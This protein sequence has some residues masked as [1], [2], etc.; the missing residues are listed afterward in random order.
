MT[1][2]PPGLSVDFEESTRASSL[3]DHH[4]DVERAEA[5]FNELSRQLSRR[6]EIA[7]SGS[8]SS[9]STAASGDV[10]K[11]VDKDDD[12]FDLREY[13]TTSNDAHQKAGIK[14]KVDFSL[15]LLGL[16]L[17]FLFIRQNVG[18][19]WEDLQVE[20]AGGMDNKVIVMGFVFRARYSLSLLQF[21]VGTLGGIEVLFLLDIYASDRS[22]QARSFHFSWGLFSG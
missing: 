6:S 21:Y 9:G 20:V 3:Q 15:I 19:V 5:E 8:K 14:H 17:N 13:L 10:E 2:P 16:P 7:R 1:G 18:V 12:R 22:S 4:V 11:G